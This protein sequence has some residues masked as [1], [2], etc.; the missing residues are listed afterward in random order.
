MSDATLDESIVPILESA[1][2][3]ITIRSTSGRLVGYFV[4]RT[5]EPYVRQSPYSIEEIREIQKNKGEC[6][7]LAEFWK[8][9]ESK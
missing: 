9:M 5:E 7:S 2:E 3:R 1:T 6:I 8:R 4:P